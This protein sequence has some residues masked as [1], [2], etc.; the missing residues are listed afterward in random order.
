MHLI[1]GAKGLLGCAIT[2]HL[3]LCG[4][5]MVSAG[6]SAQAGEWQLDLA[7][8]PAEWQVPAGLSAA[9]LCAAETRLQVCEAEPERTACVNV[10]RTLELARRLVEAGAF[11]VFPSTNLV[12]DGHRPVFLE[13]H[14]VCP[15]TEY[16]RQKV[17]VEAGLRQWPSR[18]AIVRLSKVVH[19]GMP[20]LRGWADLLRRGETVRAFANLHFSPITPAYVAEALY[21]IASRRLSGITHLSGSGQ[22]S[23]AD[24]AFALA[25][26][27]GV[28][29]SLVIP[30][31]TPDGPARSSVLDAGR[32]A[33]ELGV[34]QP[35]IAQI[36]GELLD[37]L[38]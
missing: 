21:A 4:A 31:E 25:R 38:V 30:A 19:P 12:F 20:L 23:Y 16:A 33:R 29:E 8:D 28:R 15:V 13:G 36:V 37:S 35:E 27:L 2:Q 9:Y 32:A 7:A 3:G 22:M 1:V 34:C 26:R 5:P 18:T 10:E 6:R 17:R 24:L 11:V 14:S